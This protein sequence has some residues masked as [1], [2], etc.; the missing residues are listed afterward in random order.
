MRVRQDLDARHDAAGHGDGV[1]ADRV[2]DDGDR[3]LQTGQPAKLQGPEPGPER[4][5]VDGQQRDVALGAYGEDFR[6]ELGV[7]ASA[8]DL[9]FFFFFFFKEKESRF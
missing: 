3:I 9:S 5:V 4:V 7:V 6:K 8:L 2:P 1:A